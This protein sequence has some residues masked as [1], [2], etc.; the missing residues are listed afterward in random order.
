VKN[1]SGSALRYL[2]DGDES[3]MWHTRWDTTY[4]S[5]DIVM[6]LHSINQL[7]KI[8]YLPR[9][10]A[11]NGTVLKGSI[12]Y[13][14]D[15]H[16]WTNAGAF[17]WT[18]TDEVKVFTFANHPTAKY[19]KWTI[20]QGVGGFGSGM[21][22]YV[23]RVPGTESYLP[24]DINNDR[25]VDENDF[26]SYINYTGLKQGDS[27]FEG[28][29]SKGDVNQNG[30]IDAYD[31]SVVATQLEGRASRKAG[32]KIAGI[33]E[34]STP[35]KAYNTDEIIEITVRGKDL[36]S[37]NALGFALPYN[38]QDYEFI[39]VEPLNMQQMVNLTNDR[40]HTDGS[41]ALY[42]TFVN[43]GQKPY[44]EGSSDL[45]ILK[46]KAKR[47]LTFDLKLTESLLVDNV[48]TTLP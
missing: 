32:D 25:L 45:F 37:V 26:T 20:N 2:F 38:Q 17:E 46:F 48:G 39:G 28:Y 33:I 35:K 3:T 31:I 11:G 21:E 36:K 4:T 42:P 43:K 19:V 8:H 18:R 30:R 15:Q 14:N 9:Q 10:G 6:D 12:A 23:F 44:L 40:L 1:Q 16:T 27:D 24:G 47:K 22:L 34:L 5:F 29:V 13:S 7:D 41:K